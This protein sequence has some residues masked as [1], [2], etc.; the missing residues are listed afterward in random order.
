MHPTCTLKFP[1]CVIYLIWHDSS[2]FC[3]RIKRST[4]KFKIRKTKQTSNFFKTSEQ[5]VLFFSAEEW[6]IW[7]D[8]DLVKPIT[9]NKCMFMSLVR[10]E[11]LI[12]HIRPI[13]FIEKLFCTCPN[14]LPNL[15]KLGGFHFVHAWQTYYQKGRQV[16]TGRRLSCTITYNL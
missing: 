4:K 13:F 15:S 14:F 10:T 9:V 6:K 2:S 1:Y 11:D 3:F 8:L 7:N 5:R 12:T 16:E